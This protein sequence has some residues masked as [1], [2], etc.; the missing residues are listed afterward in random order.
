MERQR[1]ANLFEELGL[2]P[3][4]LELR[5]HSPSQS[6]LLYNDIDI[7]LDTF[8]TPDAPPPPMPYGWVCRSDGSWRVDVS[9]SCAVFGV[10]DATNGSAITK[11]N[12]WN[13]LF[14]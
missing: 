8:P 14:L 2:P 1:V 5:G 3:E 12:W 10:L 4:R 7:A 11:V 9:P 13:G 6:T